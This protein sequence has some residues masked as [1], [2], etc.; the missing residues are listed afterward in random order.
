MLYAA[1][2]RLA[3]KDR[4]ITN[5]EK[6]NNQHLRSSL[7]EIG[8]KRATELRKGNRH[9]FSRTSKV[10]SVTPIMRRETE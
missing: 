9:A 6:I 5:F 3:A 1:A 10:N 2:I 8:S 7:S 4:W